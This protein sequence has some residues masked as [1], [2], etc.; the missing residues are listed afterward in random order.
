MCGVGARRM[1]SFKAHTFKLPTVI[2]YRYAY[3][4]SD[5]SRL[6][7]YSYA[8]KRPGLRWVRSDGSG[9]GSRGTRMGGATSR[10]PLFQT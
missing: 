8:D 3:H 1:A 5:I 10:A 6:R 9:F 4:P 2:N 7:A